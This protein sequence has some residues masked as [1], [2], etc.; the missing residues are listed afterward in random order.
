MKGSLLNE[1]VSHENNKIKKKQQIAKQVAIR[2]FI[3]KGRVTCLGF[4]FI[5]NMHPWFSFLYYH[6]Q[7]YTFLKD[8]QD[9]K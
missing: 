2:S 5:L 4:D 8:R 3:K 1:K 7:T 6:H 9:N